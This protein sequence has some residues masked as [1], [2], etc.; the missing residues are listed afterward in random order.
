M[1]CLN[2]RVGLD[3]HVDSEMLMW[4]PL[5]FILV[6]GILKLINLVPLE[7]VLHVIA[8]ECEMWTFG[9]MEELIR[10]SLS[11]QQHQKVMQAIAKTAMLKA[12]VWSRWQFNA[13][14]WM[15]TRSLLAQ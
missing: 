5:A 1:W 8:V 6:L 12:L 11:L 2:T 13:L 4:S 7:A 10:N 14:I 9:S 3:S 15:L